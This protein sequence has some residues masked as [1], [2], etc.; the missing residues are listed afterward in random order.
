MVL[1]IEKGANPRR[2][3]LGGGLEGNSDFDFER[4]NFDLSSRHPSGNGR[5]VVDLEERSR[6]EK[7]L[8]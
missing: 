2:Q 7:C 5:K 8:G 6:L 4:A 3:V 1:L